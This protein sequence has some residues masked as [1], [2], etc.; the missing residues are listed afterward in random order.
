MKKK[1]LLLFAAMAGMC[2]FGLL[3][4]RNHTEFSGGKPLSEAQT[5]ALLSAQPKESEAEVVPQEEG[6]YYFVEGSGTVY[7]SEASCTH[8]KK[9]QNIKIG[10]LA[11]ALAAGKVK[12]C[13]TCAKKQ[14]VELDDGETDRTC[15]YTAGG[16]V[17]HYDRSCGALARSGN[18]LS[19][20]VDGALL[21]GKTRPCSRCGD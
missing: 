13:A 10:T 4:C 11:Q 15:Y 9:S 20:T 17:W 12:L 2:A 5:K 19:G 3:S 21:D 14:S 1:N 7:H 6:A 8:L 16:T 18:V